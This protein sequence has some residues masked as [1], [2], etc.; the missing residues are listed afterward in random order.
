MHRI[1]GLAL[2]A[3]FAF[4]AILAA[5]A[6]AETTLLADWLINGLIPTSAQPAVTE[7]SLEL[8]EMTHGGTL[9]LC[10]G[11]F[12]GT[13]SG[14]SGEDEITLVEDLVGNDV[15]AT[16]AQRW[17]NCEYLK[18]SPC[19]AT[20]GELVEVFP[21]GLPWKTLLV[22][23]VNEKG[24]EVFDDLIT[25]ATAGYLVECKVLGIKADISC[26]GA[27]GGLVENGASD[28]LSEFVLTD[29]IV[30]P[31]AKCSTPLGEGE[32]LLGGAGLTT[33]TA[34]TLTVS[35]E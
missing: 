12:H 25:T 27:T 9:I 31:L 10:S 6:S 4:S 28:V 17:V 16:S 8:E 14:N 26:V 2:V 24:A 3:V 22:L 21:L 32:G 30:T 35:S 13:V 34:G 11:S 29:G 5:T 33:S 19:E 15:T 23:I 1:L 7:G 20:V 18:T